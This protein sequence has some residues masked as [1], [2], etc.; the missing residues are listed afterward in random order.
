[1]L[2]HRPRDIRC[3]GCEKLFSTYAPLLEHLETGSCVTTRVQLD[4]LAIQCKFSKD[5]VRP[6][7]GRY[8]RRGERQSCYAQPVF[9]SHPKRFG[10]SM[11]DKVFHQHG[12][13]MGHIHSSCHHPL[14]YQCKGCDSQHADL[15]DLLKHVESTSC[16]EG[17]SYGTGSIGELLH[18]LWENLA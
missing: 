11:C 18:H 16:P 5:Y 9:L 12:G 7:W 3:W 15:S 8:L 17:I 1:M 4:Q 14:V 6:G 10:C 2:T 13:M